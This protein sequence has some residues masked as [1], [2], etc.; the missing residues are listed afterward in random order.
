M[1][2]ITKKEMAF[3]LT[4]VKSPGAVYNANS[5]AMELHITP[6]GA[7]KIGKRLI[8]EGVL[9]SEQKGKA[10]FYSLNKK[11][12]YAKYYLSFLLAQERITASPYVKRWIRD[13]EKLVHT[14][15]IILFG[16]I[17]TKEKQASDVD[18][19]LVTDQKDFPKLKEEVEELNKISPK[20]I[21]PVYQSRKDLKANIFRDKV[22]QNAIKGIIVKGEELFI[23][24]VVE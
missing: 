14:D 1:R 3:V 15:L 12:A 17:L 11:D 2:S 7:L 10:Y 8:G 16:S 20:K 4:L 23:E 13:I 5:L 22:V 24:E 19:L 18:V 9:H 6:M 21:H